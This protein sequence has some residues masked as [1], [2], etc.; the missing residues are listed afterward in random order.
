[1][2]TTG[3]SLKPEYYD[4]ALA[5]KASGLW[6]EV[7]PEN[8]FAAGG[9]RLT[10]LDRIRQQHPVSLHGVSLSLGGVDPLDREHLAK[11]RALID[12]VAPALVSEHLAW[13]RH[14]GRYFPDLLP[15]L[16]T[17]ESLQ[18]IASR[19]QQ[20]QD[21]L[22]RTI[23]IENPSHYLALHGHE[24]SEPEFLQKLCQQT[25]CG[26]LLDL[27]NVAVSAHNLNTDPA[28]YLQHF[29]L[30]QVSEIHLAGHRADARP[31]TGLL[32]DS[33]DCAVSEAVWSL[34]QSVAPQLATIPVLIERD[35]NIPAFS[36]LLAERSHAEALRAP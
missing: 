2:L 33:H 11:W 17:T 10:W 18:H 31:E 19:I 34:Y 35:G 5:A 13:S 21:A 15:V 1:M 4:E 8:Y 24:L 22:G 27:N 30:A 14:Q 36:D 16:R 3:L 9:P 7:H 29:P 6:Y 20:T 12:R 23:A 25:G 28:D 32:I 26:L